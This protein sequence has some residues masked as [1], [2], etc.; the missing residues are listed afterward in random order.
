MPNQD[1]T[2]EQLKERLHY[3]P[4]TGEFTWTKKHMVHK[5]RSVAGHLENT[6]YIS[7]RLIYRP[8]LAHRLAF[9]YMIGSF[10]SC[11]VDHINGI[12]HDNR[13]FNL[14]AAHG[15]QPTNLQNRREPNKGSKSGSLGVSWRPDKKKWK[16]RIH[17][18]YKEI[19]IG[20]FD[21][22]EE[23]SAAYFKK[24]KEVHEFFVPSESLNN[25]KSG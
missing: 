17:V 1:I 16:A 3:D 25:L 11:Q 6:G 7:I 22:K 23:A 18:N 12:R 13:W 20:Y 5:K 24:K 15:N 19:H 21:S 14:R 2:Q 10:P 9:L 4:D 8:Y